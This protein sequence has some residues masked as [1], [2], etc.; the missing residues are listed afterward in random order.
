MISNEIDGPSYAVKLTTALP[1]ELVLTSSGVINA[2]SAV[3][4]LIDAFGTDSAFSSSTNNLNSIGSSTLT[5]DAKPP[6]NTLS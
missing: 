6:V 1:S 5:S 2:S 4:I 3:S